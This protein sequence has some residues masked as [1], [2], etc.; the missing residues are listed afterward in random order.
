[1][2]AL[3]AGRFER[4][5]PVGAGVY[6][7][8]YK[9]RDVRTNELRA[10]KTI[11]LE[12]EGVPFT[13]MREVS[14]LK[15]LAHRNVVPLREALVAADRVF[16][17]MELL[18]CNLQT[19]VTER[20]GLDI[21]LCA[22]FTAQLLAGVAHCHD[23]RILHRDLKPPNVLVR[24]HDRTLKIADFGLA[25]AF[26]RP[27]ALTHEVVTLWYR[28]PEILL[29]EEHYGTPVD[30]WSIG[31]I[32]A[33]MATAR[34]LFPGDSEVDEL[35]K[36]FRVRDTPSEDEWPGVAQLP[37]Y[38]PAF[39]KWPALRLD[40]VVPALAGP[41]ADLLGRCLAYEPASRISCRAALA[42][43]LATLVLFLL[44][45]LP[46][47]CRRRHGSPARALPQA[48]YPHDQI[49]ERLL[50]VRTSLGRGK[51]RHCEPHAPHRLYVHLHWYD[52]VEV[53]LVTD[54]RDALQ[55]GGLVVRRFDQLRQPHVPRVSQTLRVRGIV[56]E[57][58]ARRA[59]IVRRGDRPIPLLARRVPNL[60]FDPR[61]VVRDKS[62]RREL[63]T[64]RR[65]VSV[66]KRIVPVHLLL[67][68]IGEEIRLAHPTVPHEHNFEDLGRSCVAFC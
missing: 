7:T 67:R 12:D 5:E 58:G 20:G 18:D 54:Q 33:E 61:A 55:H 21:N 13:V 10:L 52:R 6:G 34:P 50:N 2:Q 19:Y 14:L 31:C 22:S 1:M 8:V 3:L 45:F 62:P 46:T 4:L 53:R 43:D 44:R 9:V 64:H 27:R 56:Y 39:P 16:L 24:R 35:F 28:A 42:H 48:V 37:Y 57:H 29:G 68:I 17:V 11:P 32:L 15:D 23:R 49:I 66:N 36:I 60:G 59:S 63:H 26:A 51:L 47:S 38:S 25:R 65:L 30:V 41:A 40:K